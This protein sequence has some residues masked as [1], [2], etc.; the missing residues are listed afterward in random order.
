MSAFLNTVHAHVCVAWCHRPSHR[1]SPKRICEGSKKGGGEGRK[2][3]GC[4]ELA[5][6]CTKAK[7]ILIKVLFVFFGQKQF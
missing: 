3:D 5:C 4:L 2:E 7:S 1:R 6:V